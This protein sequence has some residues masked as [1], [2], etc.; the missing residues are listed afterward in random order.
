MNTHIRLGNESLARNDLGAAKNHFL[1]ALDDPDPLIQ[2]IARH[3]LYDL[4]PEPVY[5]STHSYQQLYH[6]PPCPAKNVIWARHIVWFQSAT[7]AEAAGFVP[8][9][10]C[11][12]TMLREAPCAARTATGVA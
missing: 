5:A 3:R 6:R 2:R 10:N 8:C 12:P 11:R 4:H 1:A 9:H 7:D